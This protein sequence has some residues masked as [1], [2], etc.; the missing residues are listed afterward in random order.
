MR[1]I[2]LAVNY[3]LKINISIFYDPQHDRY[4]ETK[5]GIKAL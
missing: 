5:I 2:L 3:A 1:M 4:H